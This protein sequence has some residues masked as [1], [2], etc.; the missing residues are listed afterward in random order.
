MLT[1]PAAQPRTP[2]EAMAAMLPRIV[3]LAAQTLPLAEATGRV[4]AEPIVA[5]RPSP[6]CDVSA[7]DGYAVRRSDLSANPLPVAG[8]SPIGHAPLQL[9]PGRCVRL[10]TGA[11]VP[12]EADAVIRREDVEESPD[13]I[14]LCIPAAKVI[15]GQNIR[16]RGENAA[17]G[18]GV[19]AAGTL[20]SPAV[21]CALAT[22]GVASPRVHR[23]VRVA[24]VTTGDELQPPDMQ[25]TPWQVRNA[26]G[27]ALHAMLSAVPWLE[28]AAQR[29]VHDD[30]EAIRHA[31]AAALAAADAVVLTG[32][33][34]MGDHDLVPQAVMEAGGEVVFHKLPIRPGKPVLGA[35]GPQGQVIFGL[36][37]N[38]VS[39]LVT[40]RRFLV[41]ALAQCAGLHRASEADATV[42]L[43]NPD[44]ATLGLTWFRPVKRVN[45][46][47]AELLPTQGS[48]DVAAA[49]RSDGFVEVPAGSR[50]VR[51]LQL[52][53]WRIT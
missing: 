53:L 13:A 19:V 40:A 23:R 26:N 33:V 38:P 10:F 30:A 18:A 24:I 8:E 2:E 29:H 47:Y 1:T 37:G 12:A 21:A 22:F 6:A 48:G 44:D 3:T 17:A 46:E 27:P 51:P 20:I 45:A 4:L 35:I 49:A 11:A 52:Y 25:V 28:V 5:D 31:I 14:R 39:V 42:T 41:A 15:D 7:M 9:P 34:S 32:G 36:P 50:A 43:T 16:R